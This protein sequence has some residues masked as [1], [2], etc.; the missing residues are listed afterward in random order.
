VPAIFREHAIG[1]RV[2]GLG[3]LADLACEKA[4]GR[5]GGLRGE[6]RQAL[7][8]SDRGVQNLARRHRLIGDAQAPSFVSV[9]RR[10]AEA[11]RTCTHRPDAR[12]QRLQA[13]RCQPADRH[14]G[15]MPTRI[16]G[17]HHEVA[18]G[19]KNE[20]AADGKTLDGGNN[21]LVQQAQ[22]ARHGAGI[23]LE[24]A[25]LVQRQPADKFE[26]A[27]RAKAGRRSH[28]HDAADRRIGVKRAKGVYRAGDQIV[29][30]GIAPLRPVQGDDGDTAAARLLKHRL[31]PR[32]ARRNRAAG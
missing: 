3:T 9:E 13:P 19:S 6:R 21:G 30:H 4:F 27:A 18:G 1:E 23:G 26:V 29:V 16:P 17:R 20:T 10:D 5:G 31:P 11:Q 12:D 24:P 2:E 8:L 7:R 32:P 25:H 14:L 22:H 28:Q 15:E